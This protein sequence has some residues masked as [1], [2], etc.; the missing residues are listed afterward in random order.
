MRHNQSPLTIRR[1]GRSEPEV[2][3]VERKVGQLL[4]DLEQD[5]G[6]EVVDIDIS[7]VVETDPR[8]RAVVKKAVDIRMQH[9]PVKSWHR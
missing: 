3:A 9:R 8:G 7:D 5:T 1:L 2:E 4:S 6:G